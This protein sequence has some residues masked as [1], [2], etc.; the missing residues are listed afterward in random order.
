MD[1]KW[2][3]IPTQA[4]SLF[5]VQRTAALGRINLMPA[6]RQKVH[7]QCLA[8]TQRLFAPRLHRVTVQQHPRVLLAQQSADLRHGADPAGK[9]AAD[10]GGL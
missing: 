10:A 7:I 9:L 2:N 5:D 8:Q 1:R 6:D 3:W 4:A